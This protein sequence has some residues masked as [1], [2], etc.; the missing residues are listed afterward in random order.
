MVS[1]LERSSVARGARFF[2][3]LLACGCALTPHARAQRARDVLERVGFDQRLDN[4]I[5]LDLRFTDEDGKTVLLSS[6]F[7]KRPVAL[8]LVYYGCPML[9]TQVLNGFVRTLRP[10]SFDP[11]TDFEIVTVSID[12]ND[13]SELARAKKEHYLAEY[14][15]AKAAAGWHWLTGDPASIAR[16]CE[17]VGFRYVHDAATD[18]FAHASGFVVATP[19]G[20]VSKYFYGIEYSALDLRLAL[21]DASAGA[22][23][24]LADKVLLLCY[25]Y[26]PT[27]GKYGVQILWT[28]RF[29]G[30]ATVAALLGFIVVMLRRDRKATHVQVGG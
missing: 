5:P 17:S 30:A 28:I 23:G 14:G 21:V 16:L 20:R 26:D 22:I 9:C 10:M 6:F 24:S 19:D 8:T 1:L 2:A 4:Q 13:T 12:P 7:G 25:H 29:L 11:G 15:R 3:A 27:T 18:Q